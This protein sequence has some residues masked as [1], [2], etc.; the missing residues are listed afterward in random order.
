LPHGGHRVG[1]FAVAGQ[2]VELARVGFVIVKLDA[3][4]TGVPLRR[5]GRA[6]YFMLAW[7]IARRFFGQRSYD[8]EAKRFHPVRRFYNPGMG[9]FVGAAKGRR[10]GQPKENDGEADGASIRV[11]LGLFL[12]HA[13]QRVRAG[14]GRWP[15][16]AKHGLSGGQ[17]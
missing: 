16:A 13:G 17:G 11:D 9:H 3:L 7:P 14:P 1:L 10:D 8:D 2:I 12:C 5:G 4:L 6:S 15:Q